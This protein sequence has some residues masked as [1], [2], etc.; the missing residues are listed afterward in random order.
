M[1][2]HEK[3]S[4]TAD[5]GDEAPSGPLQ[6]GPPDA[7]TLCMPGAGRRD[8]QL[9]HAT[10]CHA[11]LLA[12][13]PRPGAS[14]PLERGPFPTDV[15]E[16]PGLERGL[17]SLFFP[18][19]SCVHV[20]WTFLYRRGDVLQT[21]GKL[22]PCLRGSPGC[23]LILRNVV[24]ANPGP[25]RV[26][27]KIMALRGSQSATRTRQPNLVTQGPVNPTFTTY[28]KSASTSCS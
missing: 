26:P 11:I 13:P 24:A 15:P 9:L 6:P 10:P 27:R 3:T 12:W 4:S 1:G 25:A 16:T 5:A 18:F 17:G 23:R 14:M 20:G 21:K 19:P 7:S 28:H 22:W 2:M 8:Q